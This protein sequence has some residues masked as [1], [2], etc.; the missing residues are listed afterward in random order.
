MCLSESRGHTLA[1][2]RSRI[3][4][5][6]RS[7]V[8]VAVRVKDAPAAGGTGEESKPRFPVWEVAG[9]AGAALVAKRKDV[10]PGEP[11]ADPQ[12]ALIHVEGWLAN[13]QMRPS[14]VEMYKGVYGP[15]DAGWM[16]PPTL[17]T[18]LAEA[19]QNRE[20]VMLRSTRGAGASG[21][22]GASN[23]QDARPV[24]RSIRRQAASGGTIKAGDATGARRS[25]ATGRKNVEPY[26]QSRSWI[27]IRLLD[28]DDAPV[29]GIAYR[30]RL[31]DSSVKEGTLD[32]NGT[33]RIDGI[34]P[35]S[36][37]LSFPEIDRSEWRRT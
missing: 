1:E 6:F 32:E 29:P 33:A 30:L 37:V 3:E 35:G 24:L 2:L 5:E 26:N 12:S 15:G 20:L 16:S 11:A 9:G 4:A 27:E 21:A 17:K 8:L 13:A 7:G 36:C 18:K 14:L 34:A 28:E 23:S 25:Q 31:P 10:P 19:F 22:S